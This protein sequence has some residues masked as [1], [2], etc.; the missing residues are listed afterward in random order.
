VKYGKSADKWGF[1][2]FTPRKKDGWTATYY[3]T[4]GN[5][6]FACT[7]KPTAVSCP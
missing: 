1:T 2:I 4:K 5:D 3:S 7:V 6:K